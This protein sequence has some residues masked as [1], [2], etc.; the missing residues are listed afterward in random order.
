M[1]KINLETLFS[2]E[3]QS[4][5]PLCHTKKKTVNKFLHPLADVFFFLILNVTPRVLK[6]PRHT[7]IL[8][9]HH[10]SI[11]NCLSK[12]NTLLIHL[13][14]LHTSA[15]YDIKIHRNT[16][17]FNDQKQ[18]FSLKTTQHQHI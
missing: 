17:Y 15:C 7:Y 10:F 3:A 4:I 16:H 1:N 14:H 2:D 8:G 13:L 5:F 11:C 6:L 12:N 18:Y 9:K